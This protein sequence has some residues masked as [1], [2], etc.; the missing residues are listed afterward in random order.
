VSALN[1]QDFKLRQ[2]AR[3][4]SGKTAARTRAVSRPVKKRPFEKLSATRRPA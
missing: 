2:D 1:A 4:T 3:Q